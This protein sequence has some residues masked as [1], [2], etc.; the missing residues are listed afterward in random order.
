MVQNSSS[1]YFWKLVPLTFQMAEK[2]QKKVTRYLHASQ[3]F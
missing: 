1:I 2:M 3:A